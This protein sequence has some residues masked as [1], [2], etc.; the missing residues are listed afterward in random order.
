MTTDSSS[1]IRDQS[2]PKMAELSS[3]KSETTQFTPR[4]LKKNI[5]NK[6]L[7][8]YEIFRPLIVDRQLYYISFIVDT[9]GSYKPTVRSRQSKNVFFFLP[10]MA[11]RRR[12][13]KAQRGK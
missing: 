5:I 13:F 10:R 6:S 7:S 3:T 8:G 12:K 9:T 11:R 4:L 1:L 2:G